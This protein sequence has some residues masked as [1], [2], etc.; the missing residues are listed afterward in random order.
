MI[1]AVLHTV[2]VRLTP[3][4]ILFTIN[5]AED[6]VILVHKDFLPILEAI[7]GRIDTV[8]RF[9][10]LADDDAPAA[11]T[12][13]LRRRVRGPA[14]RRRRRASTSRTSTRTP[15]RPPSTRPAP[16]ACPRASTSATASWCCTPS[17]RWPRSA[18]P[19][20]QGRFH[21]E[22]VYMPLTPDVPRPRLGRALPGDHDGRQAGLPGALR[23]RS[24]ARADPHREGHLLPLRADDPAHAAAQPGRRALRPLRPHDA[25]R[26][27]GAAQGALPRG[28]APRHRHPRRL[29]D[30]RDLPDPDDRA[31]EARDARARRGAPGRD[32]LPHRPAAAAGARAAR[33]R[34]PAAT[35]RR[36]ARAPARSSCARPG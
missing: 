5:H 21:R 26:R 11:R 14:R 6:D 19:R 1:G 36:T 27:R 28:D 20:T 4:Q 17:R 12:I 35:C 25:D 3:E 16:P 15:G 8:R 10:L 23:A 32:A 2:N 18:P 24:A 9:V 34:T 22:D 33:R 29:R 13:R 7:K 30:V 31:P